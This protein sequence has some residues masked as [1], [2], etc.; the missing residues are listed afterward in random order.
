M[1][2]NDVVNRYPKNT[3]DL[4]HSELFN[5]WWYY[6]VELLPGLITKGQYE[7]K[8]PMIPRINLRNC[9]LKDMECLDL[10]TMEGLIPTLMT[11]AG[12]KRV[13]AVDAVDHCIEKIKAIKHYYNVDY[14]YKSV[15]LM[16]ELNKKIEGSF[17][18]INCSGLLYHVISPFMVLA[19]IRPLLK[20]N[21]LLILSTNVIYENEFRMEFNNCGRLQEE[22]NTFWYI[23]IPLLDYLLRFLKLAPIDCLYLKHENIKSQVRYATNKQSGYLSVICRAVDEPLFTDDDSWMKKASDESWEYQGLVDWKRVKENPV[24]QIKFIGD[25]KQ[26]TYNCTSPINLWESVNTNASVK[27]VLKMNDSHALL[28]ADIS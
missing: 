16:Y 25:N 27:E 1:N 4:K 5:Q 15:G 6:S 22:I 18:L 12:A 10:G 13:L 2:T 28:L 26:Y 17:D 9:L 20:K 19:G 7:E 24:S 23:S 14:D 21:G 8:F 3:D 11:R